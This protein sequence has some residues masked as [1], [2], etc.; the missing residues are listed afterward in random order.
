MLPSI[1]PPAI[2]QYMKESQHPPLSNKEVQDREEFAKSEMLKKSMFSGP[3]MFCKQEVLPFPT[4][5]DLEVFSAD[6]VKHDR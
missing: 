6:Q 1:G 3:C 4:V 5:Q 2:L